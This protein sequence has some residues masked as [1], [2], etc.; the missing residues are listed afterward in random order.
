MDWD[1]EGSHLELVEWVDEQRNS[2]YSRRS[3]SKHD[4]PK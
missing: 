1:E 3:N 2:G 4:G